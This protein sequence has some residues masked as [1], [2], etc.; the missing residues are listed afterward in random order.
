M[1]FFL[2]T[3][4]N[5][6]ALLLGFAPLFGTV[7]NYM[8]KAA[9]HLQIAGSTNKSEITASEELEADIM[10]QFYTGRSTNMSINQG[11]F[12]ILILIKFNIN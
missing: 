5:D 3:V 2:G 7:E 11:L 12:G 8:K 10:Y 9:G 4:K 1:Y 6:G